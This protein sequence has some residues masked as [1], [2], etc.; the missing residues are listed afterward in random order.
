[1]PVAGKLLTNRLHFRLIDY[2]AVGEP[3]PTLDS[4]HHGRNVSQNRR[5][6]RWNAGE[7]ISETPGVRQTGSCE[8]GDP[9][10]LEESPVLMDLLKWW[11]TLTAGS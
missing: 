9:R 11:P 3:Y 10:E 7:P 4:I 1:M 5:E 2:S 6:H 8:T